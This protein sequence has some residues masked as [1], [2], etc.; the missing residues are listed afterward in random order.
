MRENINFLIVNFINY[1]T[2]WMSFDETHSNSDNGDRRKWHISKWD[3]FKVLLNYSSRKD[4][5]FWQRHKRKH[6]TVHLKKMPIR[7]I[8]EPDGTRLA[9]HLSVLPLVWYF[10][11]KNS[12]SWAHEINFFPFPQSSRGCLLRLAVKY[13]PNEIA[14]SKLTD[15]SW[16]RRCYF[17]CW[18]TEN[19]ISQELVDHL[20][21]MEL[22]NMQQNMKK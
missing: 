6:Q 12:G 4:S 10:S 13:N 11:K 16:R 8:I 2:K 15:G 22:Q 19:F 17:S 5:N 3:T 1:I 18:N 7:R 14:C 9:Y 21:Y 20:P